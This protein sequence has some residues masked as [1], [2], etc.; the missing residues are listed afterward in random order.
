MSDFTRTDQLDVYR[1]LSSGEQVLAGKLAQ[2]RQGVF[3]QYAADYLASYP[4]LSPFGLPFDATL[5]QAPA[6]P[7]GK[8]FGVFADS[9]PDGW[10]MRVMDRVLRQ[11]GVL[12]SQVTGMDRLAYVGDR[13]AGALEYAPPDYAAV[14]LGGGTEQATLDVLGR[15]A[16]ALFD[17]TGDDLQGVSRTLAD[18]A[19]SGGARPK[20]QIWLPSDGSK[21]AHLR[22]ASG[23]TPWLVKF[24]STLL[25]LGHEESLCEAAYLAL[26]AR[27]GIDVP[28]WRLIPAPSSSP[29]IAWLA[30]KRFDCHGERGR[31]H[32]HS[33][34]GLL[35]ADYRTPSMDYEDLM[36]ASVMLCRSPAVGQRQF[37]RAVF[38]LFALN[39]DDHTKNWAFLQD[40]AGAWRP[41]P[42]Y[43]VTFSPSASGEHTTAFLGHGNA[44]PLAAM[45][46]LASQACFAHWP[47]ARKVIERV[48]DALDDWHAV[49]AEQGV[50]KSTRTL[51][52]R[53]LEA[54]RLRNRH[55]L[56]GPP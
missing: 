48:V 51:I 9:L 24:T 38:N 19:S 22:P 17:E 1:R 56:A 33:V 42:F 8:L 15:E 28:T 55:L 41:T 40:D 3:F 18:V 23:L 21:R 20:A 4:S 53:Q 13:G 44:P 49:A 32:M 16:L 31:Y 45:Q 14:D 46:R 34:C 29:A 6:A 37:A 7:H 47:R 5:H 35:D 25:P 27:A 54:V 2:N 52:A 26:A 10:G 39:Q 50:R 36:K 12:P 43:D 30:Q 11:Q